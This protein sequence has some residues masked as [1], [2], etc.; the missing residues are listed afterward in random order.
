M[1]YTNIVEN[2]VYGAQAVGVGSRFVTSEEAGHKQALFSAGHGDVVRTLIYTGRPLRV[3]RTP[4]VDDWEK[5]C[6]RDQG[7]HVKG[8]HPEPARSREAP[9]EV[10]PGAH[11]PFGQHRRSYRRYF[12]C[13][14]YR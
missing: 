6:D 5:N 8:Y 3:R 7:A 11:V 10:R 1:N 9:R 4:Y 14:D 2:L 12:A 13:T